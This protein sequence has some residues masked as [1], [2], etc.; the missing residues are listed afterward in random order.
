MQTECSVQIRR[1]AT[2]TKLRHDRSK[3]L[4]VGERLLREN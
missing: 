2:R 1:V 3:E 4:I